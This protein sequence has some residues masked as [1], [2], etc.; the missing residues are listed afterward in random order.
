MM[1][2]IDW[3]R[4]ACDPAAVLDIGCETS[5]YEFFIGL[6][7]WRAGHLLPWALPF[8]A[9]PPSLPARPASSLSQDWWCHSAGPRYWI[10][11]ISFTAWFS[12]SNPISPGTAGLRVVMCF[13]FGDGITGSLADAVNW[14]HFPLTLF[15]MILRQCVT[16]HLYSQTFFR[17]KGAFSSSSKSWQRGELLRSTESALAHDSPNTPERGA[18]SLFL[19]TGRNGGSETFGNLSE[20]IIMD[21]SSS[22]WSRGYGEPQD[23]RLDQMARENPRVTFF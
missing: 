2:A 4:A 5:P 14:S 6:G 7:V 19:H 22:H 8:P 1:N 23:S 18:A 17:R 3:L 11:V 16:L 10:R 12:G 21:L 15:L 9:R 13:L 20:F